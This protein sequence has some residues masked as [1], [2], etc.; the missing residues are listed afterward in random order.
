MLALVRKERISYKLFLILDKETD[1]TVFY[2]STL[3]SINLP[4]VCC[5]NP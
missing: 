5:V 4:F 1:T 2:K 3:L